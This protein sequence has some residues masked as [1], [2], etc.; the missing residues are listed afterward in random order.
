MKISSGLNISLSSTLN[1]NGGVKRH[2]DL[3]GDPKTSTFRVIYEE[4]VTTLECGYH[5]KRSPGPE[6][7]S[8]MLSGSYR[9]LNSF[10]LSLARNV[11]TSLLGSFY[12]RTSNISA[13]LEPR[14]TPVDEL[15]FALL[16]DGG[17]RGV[18]VLGHDVATVQQTAA[19]VLAGRTV[20]LDHL[21][22]GLEALGSQLA[23]GVR[24][25]VRLA[26]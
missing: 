21:V 1:H 11:C 15:Q 18:D 7:C 26:E 19:H 3:L 12:P 17:D 16:A 23:D 4:I 13:H 6:K 5:S 14:R 20:A 25:V 2:F 9:N 8:F 24:V 10:L 22:A